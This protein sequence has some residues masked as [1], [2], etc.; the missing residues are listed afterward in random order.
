MDIAGYNTILGFLWFKSVN[1]EIDW[2]KYTWTYYQTK[3][4]DEVK[5]IHA[6]KADQELYKGMMAFLIYSNKFLNFD[7]QDLVVLGVTTSFK[8]NCV[9]S[10]GYVQ[11]YTD[12]F[13]EEAVGVLPAHAD[14]DHTI[15]LAPGSNPSYKPIYNLSEPKQAVL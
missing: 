2:S 11:E 6:A 13:S 9:P 3:S 1:P 14:H 5:I 7:L 4:L 15:K 12:I 10:P 8:E